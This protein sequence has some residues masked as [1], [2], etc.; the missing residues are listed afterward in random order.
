MSR[1]TKCLIPSHR[2][3]IKARKVRCGTNTWGGFTMYIIISGRV[4]SDAVVHVLFLFSLIE[5]RRRAARTGQTRGN[6][7]LPGEPIAMISCS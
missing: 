2:R 3:E 4:F 5:Y 7:Y 6:I 1:I